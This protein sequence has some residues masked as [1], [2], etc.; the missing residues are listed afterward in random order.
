MNIFEN[1]LK[2]YHSCVFLNTEAL[3][4]KTFCDV[5]RSSKSLTE[6]GR[7]MCE[8]HTSLKE[9]YECSHPALD[10]LVRICVA[11]GALGA[12]LTGAG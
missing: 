9:L 7:L 4:V 10:K 6:L 1:M 8:S 3:R 11:K 5:C 12:R 2:L